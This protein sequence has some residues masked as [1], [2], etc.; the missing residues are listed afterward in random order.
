M[1]NKR[2]FCR[3]RVT[4]KAILKSF[5][6]TNENSICTHK[7]KYKIHSTYDPSG[8]ILEEIH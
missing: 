6:I 3:Q 7:L 1:S 4:N 8:N 2:D 5:G